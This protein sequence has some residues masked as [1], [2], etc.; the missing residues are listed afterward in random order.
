MDCV[1]IGQDTIVALVAAVGG[2]PPEP[3]SDTIF[4]GGI[5]YYDIQRLFF[6]LSTAYNVKICPPNVRVGSQE[7][8]YP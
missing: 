8:I 1:S 7:E 5:V 6:N 2:L 3:L 4:N